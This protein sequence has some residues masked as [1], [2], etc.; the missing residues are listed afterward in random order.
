MS[1]P[2]VDSLQRCQSKMTRVAVTNTFAFLYVNVLESMQICGGWL[3]KPSCVL[4]L[5]R[6]RF[7]GLLVQAWIRI[8]FAAM[9]VDT[10]R[11]DKSLWLSVFYFRDAYYK[12]LWDLIFVKK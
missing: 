11:T 12:I 9:F 10:P 7:Q 3:A 8:P 5:P 1:N 6:P 4:E 2:V